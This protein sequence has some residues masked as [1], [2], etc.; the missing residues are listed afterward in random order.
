MEPKPFFDIRLRGYPDSNDNGK[1]DVRL[2]LTLFGFELTPEEGQVQ[3]LDWGAF[4][5][6]IQGTVG[7]FKQFLPN[8]PKIPF[9]S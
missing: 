7:T 2:N 1:P 6:T 3:D 9:L 5:S 4:I 8:M